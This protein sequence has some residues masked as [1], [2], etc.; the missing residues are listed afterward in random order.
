M[1]FSRPPLHSFADEKRHPARTFSSS[2]AFGGSDSFV[3][4]KALGGGDERDREICRT[5]VKN[6]TCDPVWFDDCYEVPPPGVPHGFET[7]STNFRLE[8][9]DSD[10]MTVGDFL[11]SVDFPGS[12]FTKSEELQTH[13]FELVD[14]EN[15]DIPIF[16]ALGLPCSHPPRTHTTPLLSPPSIQLS[17]Q[18]LQRSSTSRS[19]RS[20]ASRSRNR[21]QRAGQKAPPTTKRTWRLRTLP[22]CSRLG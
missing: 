3:L 16:H 14:G 1:K 13:T 17:T 5:S 7:K 20:R 22:H 9:W 19:T 11:G 15:A 21:I 10:V 8:V 2:D 4:I 6:D 12:L 18:I